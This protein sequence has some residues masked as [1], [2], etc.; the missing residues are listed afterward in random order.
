MPNIPEPHRYEPNKYALKLWLYTRKEDD[1]YG[2][3][4]LPG[5]YSTR[6]FPR[7]SMFF[8]FAIFLEILGAALLINNGLSLGDALFARIAIMGSIGLVLLDL[9]LAYFLHRKE[10][11][12]SLLKNR[13]TIESNQDELAKHK[14]GLREGKILDYVLIFAI[15]FISLVKIAGVILLGTMDH[16]ALYVIVIALFMFIFYIHIK[17]TGYFFYGWWTDKVFKK[18]LKLKTEGDDKFVATEWGH[19]FESDIDLLEGKE[20]LVANENHKISLDN[21]KVKKKKYGYNIESLGILSD[22]DVTSFLQKKSITQDQ[23]MILSR[24]CLELQLKQYDTKT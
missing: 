21:K 20:E 3:S 4:T 17:K 15:F 12:R 7:D 19:Y 16:I 9:I 14:V 5:F 22:R 10:S 11:E 18:Q 6:D 24:A 23:M 8:A 2:M 1:A 13:I